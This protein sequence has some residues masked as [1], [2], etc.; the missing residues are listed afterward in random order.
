MTILWAVILFGL[1]IFFH[2]LGHFL[3]AKLVNVKVLKFSIGFGPKIFGKKIGETEYILSA[4]PLGGYVKPLGE[5]S[6]DEIPEE[7]IPR[8]YNNQPVWKRAAIVISGPIF[9]LVLAYLIFVVF[10]SASLPVV[11]PVLSDLTNTK[12]EGITKDS[13]AMNAGLRSG[14]TVLSVNGKE[15]STWVEIDEVVM[16]SPLKEVF[17][18]VKRGE[19]IIDITVT[20]QETKVR[21]KN[22]D[23]STI[24]DIGISRLSTRLEG[25]VKDSPAMKAGLKEGD[26]VLSVNGEAVGDWGEMA[27]LISGNPDTEI[28]LNVKRGD[29]VFDINVRT[30]ADGRIGISKGMGFNVIQSSSIW[31]APVKGFQAVYGWCALTL[32][33]AGRLITGNMSSKMLGG[34]IVIVNEAS[35]A[36]SSGMADYFYLIALISVNLAVINLFPVPVLDG[37]HLVFLCIEAVRGKPLNEKFQDILTKIGFGLLLMLI[38]FVLYNDTIKVIVPWAQKVWGQW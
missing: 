8:A 36:A 19:S 33:V 26:T 34:P 7:D 2:E 22:G 13:P 10:L 32:D 6:E 17:M 20:P 21:N 35:K 29:A 27:K 15:I 3:V 37:G 9:N 12:I 24:G 25:I 16:K 18:K 30:D 28:T 11:I 1:L 5:D 4:L 23:E 31:S 38:A 14:D